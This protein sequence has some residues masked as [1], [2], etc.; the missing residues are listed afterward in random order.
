MFWAA[1][2]LL[3]NICQFGNISGSYF[4]AQTCR[5][6]V[7][8]HEPNPK[9]SWSTCLKGV[10][11]SI[12]MHT[13]EIRLK[14]PLASKCQNVSKASS[15]W[16]Q[17]TNYFEGKVS[18][19]KKRKML[20][21]I[22]NVILCPKRPRFRHKTQSQANPKFESDPTWLQ[23]QKLGETSSRVNVLLVS[24]VTLDPTQTARNNDV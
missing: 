18:V 9:Q 19:P 23:T 21:W 1:I 20:L 7:A 15:V 12:W 8:Q 17:T 10:Y 13:S 11:P 3:E 4:T 22:W 16:T 2:S 24:D 14:M 5:W 6:R